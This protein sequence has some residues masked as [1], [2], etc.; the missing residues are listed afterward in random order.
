M[1][2]VDAI[3]INKDLFDKVS[4][5]AKEC[6]CLRIK[7]LCVGSLVVINERAI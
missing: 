4:F 6:P 2:K 7:M 5:Q 3:L 1:E